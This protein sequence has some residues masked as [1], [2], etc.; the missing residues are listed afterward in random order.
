MLNRG[1]INGLLIRMG[2]IEDIPNC[3]KVWVIRGSKISV[4]ELSYDEMIFRASISTGQLAKR[5]D[6]WFKRERM[7]SD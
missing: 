6:T 1:L 3:L 4:E 7:V 5:Q 2:D